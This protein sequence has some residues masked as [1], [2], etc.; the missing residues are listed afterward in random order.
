[1]GINR[2]AYRL[3]RL[4]RLIVFAA[5]PP[6]LV[7]LAIFALKGPAAW[8]LLPLAVLPTTLHVVRY[9]SVWFET[10]AVSV[11]TVV[12][13]GLAGTISG[14]VGPVGLVFRTL[15]LAVV[16]FLVFMV[17]VSVLPGWL[18]GGPESVR[19][20]RVR[21][22]SRLDA[23]TLKDRI[24]LYPGRNDE[25]AECGPARED[26]IFEVTLKNRLAYDDYWPDLPTV[27]D[28]EDED[29]DG[30]AFEKVTPDADGTIPFDITLYGIVLEST[31]ERHDVV[32]VEDGV[33]QTSTTRHRFRKGRRGTRVELLERGTPMS[34]GNQLGFWLQ[35]YAADGLFD[36]VCRA[37]GRARIAIRADA[38]RQLVMDIA[39]WFV[40]RVNR[41]SGAG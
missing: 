25:R 16:A 21:R 31:P 1:M 12:V 13:L 35:D 8:A 5:I 41:V 38:H 34:R 39:R 3:Y 28:P 6:L 15:G 23:A 24:T 18:S 2:V 20:Y 29:E 33:A 22:W 4:R 7:W 10:M 14:D 17:A 26:G 36:D 11:T 27:D 37:E 32:F 30:A 19:S 40:P 9:P